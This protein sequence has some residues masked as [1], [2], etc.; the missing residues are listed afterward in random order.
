VGC[1]DAVNGNDGRAAGTKQAAFD[2]VN[3]VAV[4][5]CE[6]AGEVDLG[7]GKVQLVEADETAVS[8][9]GNTHT[10]TV[11]KAI[12]GE[13]VRG[14]IYIGNGVRCRQ[15]GEHQAGTLGVNAT[16]DVLRFGEGADC[17]GACDG[18]GDLMGAN[19]GIHGLCESFTDVNFGRAWNGIV[20]TDTYVAVAVGLIEFLVIDEEKI[21]D[22]EQG[23]LLDDVCAD[24]AD[25]NDGNPRSAEPRLAFLPE[26]ANIS[27]KAIGHQCL[28]TV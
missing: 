19:L 21:T 2:T 16:E 28:S 4:F 20:V 26:E 10:A 11:M 12:A 6:L 18:G 22:P 25:S 14:D 17:V 27:V 13:N 9:P 5:S 15:F 8:I 3:G 7:F 1:D 24:T 23:E